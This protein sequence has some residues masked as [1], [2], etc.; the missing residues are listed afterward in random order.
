MREKIV[1]LVQ[2]RD[3]RL[4]G[5]IGEGRIAAEQV[6][7]YFED[8]AERT[9]FQPVAEALRTAVADLQRAHESIRN[10]MRPFAPDTAEASERLTERW[11]VG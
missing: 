8:L 10:A 5:D 9:D 2:A 6:G 11:R 7:A 4:I 3:F 1:S